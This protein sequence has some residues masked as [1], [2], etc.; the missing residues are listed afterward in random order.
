ME[1]SFVMP[2]KPCYDVVIIIPTLPKKP[3]QKRVEKIVDIIM[4]NPPKGL[5]WNIYLAYEGRDWNDAVNIALEAILPTVTKGFILLDDDSFPLPNWAD[6]LVD[7][8][9]SY[10]DSIL[11]FCLLDKKGFYE[12]S[13]FSYV[14]KCSRALDRIISKSTPRS[15]AQK[16]F[17]YTSVVKT[18]YYKKLKKPVKASYACFSAVLI[19]QKVYK[20][21]GKIEDSKNIIYAEDV[22]F[23]FRAMQKG[24]QSYIIPQYVF[25]LRGTTKG[26]KPA[27]Y[28]NKIDSTNEWL[29]SKWFANP[30]FVN[31]LKKQGFTKYF[32]FRFIWNSSAR[33]LK[34]RVKNNKFA[35]NFAERL[36]LVV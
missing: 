15:D 33:F 2:L 11:Q 34:H 4:K 10:P 18:S 19:P 32:A 24:Y 1:N 9:E 26:K 35:S 27:E 22:D 14:D 28:M 13:Y 25:H 8:I 7:Y 36:E 21:V 6:K 3:N 20:S 31:Y 23:S 17:A 12:Q 5:S 30:D 16:L 29:Y